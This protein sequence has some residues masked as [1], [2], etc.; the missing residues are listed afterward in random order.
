LIVVPG[1]GSTVPTGDARSSRNGHL[2]EGGPRADLTGADLG[3]ADLSSTTWVD[4]TCP[5]GT[6]SDTNGFTCIGHIQ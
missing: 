6:S 4:T 2:R 5:D 3:G 1:T